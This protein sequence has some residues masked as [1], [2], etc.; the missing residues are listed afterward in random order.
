MSWE[1]LKDFSDYEINTEYP[2]PIRKKE[3]GMIVKEHIE[4]DGYYQLHLNRTPYMKHRLVANQWIPNP[5]NLPCIDH[6]NKDR[7]DNHIE[8]LRWV[9]VQENTRNMSGGKFYRYEFIDELPEDS[10][11]VNTYSHHSLEDYYFSPSLNQFYLWTGIEYRILPI[12]TH[13]SGILIVYAR[14]TEGKHIVIRI[15]KFKRQYNLV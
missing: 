14:S 6:K 9:T 3:N 7:T 11:E 4:G 10:I 1:E 8:N 15:P 5:D 13:K 12:C 2:Y